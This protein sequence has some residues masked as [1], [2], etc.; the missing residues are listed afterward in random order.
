MPIVSP[1]LRKSLAVALGAV[2][3]L[4]TA[5][6]TESTYRPAVG[7]GFAQQGY[8]D[9]QIEENRFKVSFSG[10]SYTSRDTVERYLLY[11]AAELTLQRGYDYFIFAERDID[12]R[13]RTYS[14]PG[15][16]GGFGGGF[17]GFGNG[18]GGFGNG[19]GGGGFGG[20]GFGRGFGGGGF[21]FGGGGFG[22]PFF[23]GPFFGGGII[24]TIDKYEANAELIVGRGPKPADNIRAFDA[25]DV[26]RNLESTIV[27]PK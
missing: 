24:D 7:R 4:T 21:G 10:N 13:S 22:D 18:F 19:F 25:R 15:G 2:T 26:I 6:M 8:S 1:T 12:R 14:T 11:R 16:F 5:C 20:G 9:R 17:G 23:G 3:L 27:L